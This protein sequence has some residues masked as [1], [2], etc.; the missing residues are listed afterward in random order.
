MFGMWK[1]PTLT[2]SASPYAIRTTSAA[3]QTPMP[4]IDRIRVVA[5]AAVGAALDPVGLGGGPAQRVGPLLLDAE[6]VEHP[7]R[8]AAA[9]T[10][11]SG[12]RRQRRRAGRAPACRSAGPSPAYAPV[13]LLAGDLLLEDRPHQPGEEIPVAG[14]RRPRCT[15]ASSRTTGWAA[16]QLG[17]TG[18][19]VAQPGDR[20]GALDHPV[21]ARPVPGGGQLL[22]LPAQ[23]QR[24]RAVGGA[25]GPPEGV[26]GEPGARVP[27]AHRDRAHRATQV[28]ALRNPHHPLHGLNSR[29]R[30]IPSP[31]PPA[32][33]RTSRPGVGRTRSRRRL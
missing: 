33:G 11:G 21:R 6:R 18:Q 9:I 12:G 16:R 30:S 15:R 17:E 26:A 29:T 25:G 1:S 28:V 31:R 14:M 22:T 20:V 7:V 23:R 2:A 5:S 4:R 32:G 19:V 13:G 3:V 24:G 10:S 8:A 27:A